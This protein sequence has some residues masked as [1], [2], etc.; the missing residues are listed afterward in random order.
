MTRLHR[1]ACLA[2]TLVVTAGASFACG[3]STSLAE[4]QT[5]GPNCNAIWRV[6][7]ISH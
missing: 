7:G 2:L 6:S 4:T 5:I 1:R 3:K